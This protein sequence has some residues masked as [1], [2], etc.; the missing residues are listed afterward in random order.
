MA[1]NAYKNH[2]VIVIWFDESE[3]DG[4]NGDKADDFNHTIPEIIISDR[5]HE[6][7]GGLPYAS[8]LNY[9]HSSD[10]RTWQNIFHAGPYRADAAN[11]TDLSDLFQAGAIPKKP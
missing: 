9:S 3:S 11:A 7:V 2:G 10:L 5:A 8:P 4:V 6:N 1:S